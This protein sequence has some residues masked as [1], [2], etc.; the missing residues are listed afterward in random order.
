MPR[1]PL[2]DLELDERAST[3]TAFLNDPV[4][5]EAFSALREMYIT[6][7]EKAPVGSDEAVTAHTSLKVLQ[8]FRSTVEAVITDHKMRHKYS[9]IEYSG[10]VRSG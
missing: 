2:S 7:L 4:I 8:E 3:A 6:V 5:V 1:P 9:G 10:R